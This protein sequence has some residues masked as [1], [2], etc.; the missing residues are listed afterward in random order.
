MTIAFATSAAHQHLDPDLPLLQ[1]AA[2]ERGIDADIVVWDDPAAVWESYHTVVVR[3][4]WDYVARREEFLDW[5][6]TV[7]RLQNTPDVLRWNTDKVYLRQLQDAGVPIIE[8]R[9]DVAAE[10][11]LGDHDEWVVKPTVSAGSMDTARWGSREEVWAHSAELV[12]TGRTSMTQPYIASVDDEGETAML[13][14]GGIFSHAIR[15]GALLVAGEGVVQD[16]HSREAIT[17]RTPTP[18][19]REVAA[20]ALDVAQ[21]VTGSA[22]L[23][24]RVDLVTAADGA[25]LVIELELAE[26]SVFL[27]QSNGGAE[28]FV[29]AVLA[30]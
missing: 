24:A 8:T 3:S 16:R 25:P 15:K 12:A 9:W 11:A 7:P 13:Y 18:A 10:D 2:A 4:C 28:R 1:S 27:P 26:P 19:Q 17:A 5:A 29:D 22:F 6:A 30:L 20:A 14:F 23:Y 21:E